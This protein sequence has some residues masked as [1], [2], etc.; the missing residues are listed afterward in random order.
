MAKGFQ[1]AGSKNG[2]KTPIIEKLPV[3]NATA[4][5]SGEPIDF[6]AG[7]GVIVLAEPDDFDDPIVGISLEE[8]A[9]ND[10]KVEIEVCTDPDII[11][12]HRAKT[13]YTLTGGSTT[14]AVDS[15]LQPQTNNFWKNGAIKILTCAANSGLVGKTVGI[16]ASTGATGTLTLKETLPSALASG[17][18]VL[19]VPGDYAKGYVGYDLAADAMSPDYDA[20]GG[21][22]L[23]FLYSDIDTM[24]T[25]WK[26]LLHKYG[27]HVK[28]L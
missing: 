4:I 15:S 18:T 10:G 24:T 23:K 1:I 13:A 12:S 2:H 25:F 22:T 9:A 8:K 16:S 19:L 28:A 17:D 26:F 7:T 14:T 21:E 27:N 11:F 6:T 3:P 5:E 20:I